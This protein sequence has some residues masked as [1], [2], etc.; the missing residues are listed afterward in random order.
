MTNSFAAAAL[1]L[2]AGA[3][4]AIA[5][6][7][8]GGERLFR[9]CAACHA[10]GEGAANKVGPELNGVVGRTPGTVEGFA[11]SPAMVAYGEAHV[12]DAA[13]L[14]TYLEN[15]RQ[16]VPGNKMAYAG[17]RKPEDRADVIA[18]LATFGAGGTPTQ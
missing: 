14:D 4:P 5:Q 2:L 11:Y 17:L 12:W 8:A 1:V 10:I 6:D 13:T 16:A 3:A 18:Y 7:V 15:P 9:R